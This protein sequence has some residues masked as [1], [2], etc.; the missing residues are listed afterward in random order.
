[1]ENFETKAKTISEIKIAKVELQKA[2]FNLIHAFEKENEV[3]V[4][5]IGLQELCYA[6]RE[7]PETSGVSISFKI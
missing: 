1:M 2:L 4:E 3:W 5:Y 6:G 7:L